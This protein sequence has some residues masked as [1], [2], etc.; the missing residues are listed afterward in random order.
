MQLANI[1][2]ENVAELLKKIFFGGGGY[3]T[4][5]TIFALCKK[6]IGKLQIQ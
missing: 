3:D 6:K 4:G 2:F 5:N 1:Q